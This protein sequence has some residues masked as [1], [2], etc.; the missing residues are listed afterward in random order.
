ML[1]PAGRFASIYDRT[2]T[3]AC[4]TGG[5]GV[6]PIDHEVVRRSLGEI[7]AIWRINELLNW[8]VAAGGD[9]I[10][11][12]DAASPKRFCTQPVPEPGPPRGRNRRHNG[13]PAAPEHHHPV[14]W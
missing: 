6:T 1:G 12:A 14:N 4:K 13:K 11:V 7:H 10:H 3:W 2:H 5:N 9:D 8:Q